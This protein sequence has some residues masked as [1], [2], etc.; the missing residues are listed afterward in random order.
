MTGRPIT[1]I[2]L[3]CNLF[4]HKWHPDLCCA[5]LEHHPVPNFVTGEQWDFEG[6][7]EGPISPPELKPTTAEPG[8]CVDGFHLFQVPG[9]RER[10]TMS[11]HPA[12]GGLWRVI[13]RRGPRVAT[14]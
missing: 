3:R 11:E 9:P 6:T 8:L 2:A 4:R 7:W 1:A 12:A 5:V 13:A 10:L 14:R